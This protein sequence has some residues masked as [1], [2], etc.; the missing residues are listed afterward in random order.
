MFVN[1]SV[2]KANPGHEDA[3]ADSM[4]RFAVAARTQPGLTMCTTLRDA[5]TGDLVGLAIWESEQAARAA[6]PAIMA[7]VA[8]DDFETW[9][10]DSTNYGLSEI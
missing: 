8:G 6:G 3:L 4:R 2:M 1:V 5:E 7:A 9:V 10:A